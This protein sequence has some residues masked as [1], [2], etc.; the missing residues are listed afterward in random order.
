MTRGWSQSDIDIQTL[1]VGF[2][3]RFPFFSVQQNRNLHQRTE[4]DRMLRRFI[5]M[6][7]FPI[8]KTYRIPEDDYA[9]FYEVRNAS[10]RVHYSSFVT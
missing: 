9:C 3:M 8:Q 7:I 1:K 2:F 10:M 6:K 5:C 4:T